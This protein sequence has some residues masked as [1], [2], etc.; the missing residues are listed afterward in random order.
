MARAPA[1]DML[2]W[3]L[4][5]QLI[6]K[7]F[8]Q[9]LGRFPA[10]NI[11]IGYIVDSSEN[12]EVEPGPNLAV[13][14][15]DPQLPPWGVVHIASVATLPGHSGGVITFKSALPAQNLK[16]IHFTGQGPNTVIFST[17]VDFPKARVEY[18]GARETGTDASLKLVSTS[19]MLR[20]E[21]AQ[22]ADAVGPLIPYGDSLSITGD[23]PVIFR[24]I[25]PASP[26][27]LGGTF[28]IQQSIQSW[29]PNAKP[30]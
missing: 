21:S 30:Q 8:L 26:C 12:V 29:H 25:S 2:L 19:E 18:F 3:N 9:N 16:H 23:Q 17:P 4:H 27:G 6:S 11:R 7:M 5:G 1:N 14:T 20:G 24:V 15:T 28:Q 10:T 13:Q 22:Y